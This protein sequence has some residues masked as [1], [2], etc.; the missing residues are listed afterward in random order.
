MVCAMICHPRI[1]TPMMLMD[2]HSW[3]P[4]DIHG[5]PWIPMDLHGHGHQWTSMDIHGYP[6]TFMDLYGPLWTSM[7]LHGPPWTPTEIS[8]IPLRLVDNSMRCSQIL[9]YWLHSSPLSGRNSTLG[10]QIPH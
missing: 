4:M 8:Q 7:D 2:T 3:T 5:H 1:W 6:W 9:S 10:Q